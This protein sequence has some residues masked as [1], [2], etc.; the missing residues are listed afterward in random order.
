MSWKVE[1]DEALGIVVD[2]YVGKSSGK[3]FKDVAKK[4]IALGRE[5]GVE[6]TL[7]DALRMETDSSTTFDVYDIVEHMYNEEG[8]RANWKI[9][10]TTPVSSAARE[11]VCFYVNVC[12]NRG[13]IIEEFT[14]RNEALEWLLSHP[15]T[16]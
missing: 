15:P 16:F 1:Y 3:D 10:I 11:Q 4:R 6:K 9:A 5:K 7:I 13:W 14:K 12:K 2:T 8:R